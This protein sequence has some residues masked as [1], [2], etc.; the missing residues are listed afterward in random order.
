MTDRQ[1]VAIQTRVFGRYF[2]ENEQNEPVT[3]R[4]TSDSYL[5][6]MT[7]VQ[8]FKQKLEFWKTCF[9]HHELDS[10]STLKKFSDE[11]GSQQ[12]GFKIF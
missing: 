5:F 8:V 11:T 10:F 9:C 4:K 2:P 12:T 3:S 6:P 7:K 1:T